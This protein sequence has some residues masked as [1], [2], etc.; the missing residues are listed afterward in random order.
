MA[1]QCFIHVLNKNGETQNHLAEKS[2]HIEHICKG[3]FRFLSKEK[4]E[5]EDR[6]QVQL[7]FP[8]K[9]TQEVLGRI[10]YSDVIADDRTAYGF[11]ILNGFYSSI[12]LADCS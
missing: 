12:H 7:R 5:L 10:C 1:Q 4:F 9:H 8:D 11:S 6:I 2:F 3:G